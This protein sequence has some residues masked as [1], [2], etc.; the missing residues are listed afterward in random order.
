MMDMFGAYSVGTF[1]MRLLTHN[2]QVSPSL[3]DSIDESCLDC[4]T[5]HSSSWLSIE[6]G[7]HACSTNRS[8]SVQVRPIL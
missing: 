8:E 7:F 2:F 1:E 5:K 3:H 6:F 4:F